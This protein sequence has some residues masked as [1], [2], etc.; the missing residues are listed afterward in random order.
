[1][2]HFVFV[3]DEEYICNQFEEIFSWIDENVYLV[4]TFKNVTDTL[5]FIKKNK[6]DAIITDISL[7]NEN[8]ISIAKYVYENKLPIHV[9]LLSAH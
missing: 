7:K 4:A 3:D 2:I 8:G 5:N 6:V 9:I 1:M